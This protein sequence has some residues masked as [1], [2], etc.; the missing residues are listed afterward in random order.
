MTKR[1]PSLLLAC[2]LALLALA[3]DIRAAE[4]APAA[5]SPAPEIRYPLPPADDG[6]P[7]AG[8]LRRADWFQK[9]WNERHVAWASRGQADQGA[10]VFLG[11]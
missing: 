11:D 5:A 4:T 2:A 7:G 9:L 1:R 8:P 10:I 3:C 6:L